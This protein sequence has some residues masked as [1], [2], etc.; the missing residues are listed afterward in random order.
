M[1]LYGEGGS[2]KSKVIQ[3]VTHLFQEKEVVFMLQ[4]TS[5]TGI[6]AS[7]I[8]ER[9]ERCHQNVNNIWRRYGGRN[10]T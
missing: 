5:Y 2:G 1:M 7:L 6:A 8:E 4:K 10:Y 9:K 3:T